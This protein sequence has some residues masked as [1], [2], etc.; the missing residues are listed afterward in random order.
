MNIRS[1]SVTSGP[2]EQARRGTG[3]TRED[4]SGWVL[5][6]VLR[7]QAQTRPD[8]VFLEAEGEEPLTFGGIERSSARIATALVDLGVRFGEPVLLMLPNGSAFVETWFAINRLGA[9]LAPVNTGLK[10][11]FL[12]HVVNDSGARLLFVAESLLPV[13]AAVEGEL[14]H[15]ERIVVVPDGAAE[16]PSRFPRLAYA[17]VRETRAREVDAQVATGD[18]AMLMYTSGTTGAAKGVLAPHGHLYINPWLYIRHIGLGPED[19]SYCALP[20]FHANGLTLQVYGSL[21]A[22]CRVVLAKGFRATRWIDEVRRCRATV[23]N[24]LG[25]MAEFVY[26]QPARPD[27]HENDLRVICA[28]P[29]APDWGDAFE[30]RFAVKLFELYGTTEVNCPLYAP[31]EGDRRFGT[32]GKPLA[33]WYD[34]DVVDPATDEPV[35]PD[36]IGELVIRPKHPNIFMLGYKGQPEATLAAWRN[37]WFHTGDAVRRDRDGWYYFID[38]MKDRIRHKGENVSSFEVEQVLLMHPDVA[39]AAV[40]GVPHDLKDRE[41]DIKACLVLKPGAAWRPEALLAFAL[42]KMPRYAVPRY[43][44]RYDALPKTPTHKVQRHLLRA[45]AVT[46]ATWDREAQAETASRRRV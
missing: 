26:R 15:L 21:I 35:G 1:V 13:L 42:D 27:D 14:K 43:Y 28:V 17:E 19:T 33:E 41:N 45:A 46:D 25:G 30:R 44:Q 6:E 18:V 11:P 34:V 24:L 29:I 37:F 20:L 8:R 2:E 31:L 39:E 40:V 23:T 36:E 12:S 10:G 7:R 22:G 4:R 3:M 9:V 16:S 32:C 38:R 5:G